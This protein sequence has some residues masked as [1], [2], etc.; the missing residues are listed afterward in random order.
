MLPR[1][2]LLS[3]YKSFIC[4][5][6]DYGNVI[7]DQTYNDSFHAT[8][9]PYQHEAAL[10]MTG[11]IKGSSTEKLY[12]ELG[13]EH[14]RSRRWFRKPTSFLQNTKEQITFVFI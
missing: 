2:A 14:L 8:L 1:E 12:Q 4:P 3:I 10:A 7:F 6:F 9:K 11:E 13:I 5:H